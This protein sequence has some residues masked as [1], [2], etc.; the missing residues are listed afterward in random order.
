MATLYL[1][2]VSIIV[3]YLT[4][5]G[6]LAQGGTLNTYV[7]GTVNTP[8]TT[9][10]DSTGTQP[11]VNPMTL[12]AAARP[13]S[14]SGAPVEFW[15]PSGTLVKLVV[16]DAGGNQLVY[17]DNLPA[18]ND[19]GGAGAP[20]TVLASPAS[21]SGADLVANAMRSY[22]VFASVRAANV[23]NLQAGQTLIIAVEG[24]TSVND[25]SGGFFQWIP[26]SVLPDDGFNILKPNAA[27]GA[28]RYSRLANAYAQV[29]S[30]GNF[31]ATVSGLTAVVTTTVEWILESCFAPATGTL[32]QRVTLFVDDVASGNRGGP[33]G[34]SNT[35]SMTL[36]GIPIG[37]VP[38]NNVQPLGMPIWLTDNGVTSIG[39]A[40]WLAG[41][42][43][44]SKT[45][46]YANGTF[47]NTGTK[48]FNSFVMTYPLG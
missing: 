23:P 5:L 13:A 4:N 45:G 44:F 22:D 30:S 47:T 36:T 40:F 12:N 46:A 17:L 7:A 18:M 21:G 1:S 39:Q 41:V 9:Y 16:T 15:V 20:L 8:V 6:L 10:T 48:G 27:T 3:Q 33:S 37:L 32:V 14:G 11:N 42:L 28:G 25:G 35:T 38:S 43:T 19:P 2:P 24:Q 34:T 26:S 31:Q 29:I